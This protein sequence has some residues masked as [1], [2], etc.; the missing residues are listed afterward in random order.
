MT[1][2]NSPSAP[3]TPSTL[4]A[5]RSVPRTGV[6]YVTQEA[7]VRGYRT[8]DPEWSNLAHPHPAAP[9]AG[10]QLRRRGPAPRGAGPGAGGDPLLE[11]VQSHGQ[12][13]LGRRAGRLGG[14]GPGPRLHALDRRVLLPL[15]LELR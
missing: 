8:G 15:R 4:Q 12:G 7:T 1:T 13:H 6:V 14:R 10:L 3:S 9:R 5:F 11:S 2:S